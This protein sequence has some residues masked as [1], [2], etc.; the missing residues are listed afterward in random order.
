MANYVKFRRGNPAAFQ[1]ILNN[2]KAE[3]DTLYFIY[4]ENESTSSL[5]L[6]SKLIASSTIDGATTLA[7]LK[8]VL[9]DS[10]LDNNDCLIFDVAQN[11]WVNKPIADIL[12]IFVGTNGESPAV[13]GL[14]PATTD[15]NK[16]LFLRSDGIWVDIVT[17]IEET[18]DLKANINDVYTKEESDNAIEAFIKNYVANLDHLKRK[19]VVSYDSIDPE[20]ENSDRYV[21]MVPNDHGSYD[22]YMVIN[23]IIEKIG[24]WTVDLKDYAK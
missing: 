3:D 1:A 8:D 18:L 22:E 14:V 21:Y 24:D 2:N 20:E 11:G 19:I 23:G 4:E 10:N 13:A 6:G 7:A 5:Y 16:N 15:T 9:I 12:P 17:S